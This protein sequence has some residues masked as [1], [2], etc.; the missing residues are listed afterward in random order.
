MAVSATSPVNQTQATNDTTSLG[1][2]RLAENFDMFLTLLTTQLKNQDPT[3]PMD[4]NQFMAQLVQMTSVEQQL[5]GNDL[6]KQLV[7]NT[8][9]N[10]GNVVSLI[11]KEVRADVA[12][13]KLSNGEAKWGY[14]LET[15]ADEVKI[16][17]LDSRGFPVRTIALDAEAGAAG[18]HNFV[19]DGKSDSG[20]AQPSGIYTLRI[21]AKDSSGETVD[22][23]VFVQGVVTGVE[24]ADGLGLVTVNGGKVALSSISSIMSAPDE[25]ATDP[26][27]TDQTST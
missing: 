13:A 10:L 14:T 15:A 27:P 21:T 7:A 4:S 22:S 1:R 9:T 20:E 12:D 3:A 2:T 6:L 19:W 17:V 11:G 26:N 23:S 24:Q 8:S 16:E 5:A 18:D 25:V